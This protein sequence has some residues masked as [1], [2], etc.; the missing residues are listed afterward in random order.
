MSVEGCPRLRP[1]KVSTFAIV[2]AVALNPNI[3]YFCFPQFKWI[4]TLFLQYSQ[5]Y[6]LVIAIGFTVLFLC[7]YIVDRGRDSILPAQLRLVVRMNF[8]VRVM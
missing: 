8:C 3:C 2:E 4:S 7:K 6:R 1:M 5:E